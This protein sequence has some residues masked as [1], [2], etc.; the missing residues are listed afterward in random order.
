MFGR[1]MLAALIVSPGALLAQVKS[2][3]AEI[4]SELFLKGQKVKKEAE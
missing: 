4:W 1:V 3:P 2:G